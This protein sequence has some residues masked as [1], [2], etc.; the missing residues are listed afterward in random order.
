MP[1]VV[2]V[3]ESVGAGRIALQ[4]VEVKARLEGLLCETEVR[5]T[6][7]NLEDVNI[8]AVYTFPL[9][10]GAVLL[11][12]TAEING[13]S[14]ESTV[15]PKSAA[16]EGYEDAIEEG[17]S[18][19]LLE[20]PEPGLFTMNVG[21]LQPGETATI[22]L[23]YAELLHWQGDS[24]QFRLPTTIAPRYGDA[25]AAG[26]DA[27]QVP[28]HSLSAEHGFSLHIVI[29]GCLARA[30]FECPSHPLAVRDTEDA[31]ELH[32][33]GGAALM[34]RDF[35][36]IL[37]ETGDRPA[38]GIWARDGE[39]YVGLAS[40]HPPAV[41][42]PPAATC[43][44]IVV[45]CSGSM[46][47]DSIAQAKEALRRILALLEPATEFNLVL[48]GSGHRL[49][50][51][52][53]V[54]ATP[55]HLATALA[56]V[57]TIDADMGGT[58]IGAALDAAYRCGG[59]PRL[60]ASVLLVTD[61]EVWDDGAIVARAQ[62]SGHRIFTVG[63]GSA[64]SEAFVRALADATG[65]ACE[66]V[67]PREDMAEH[68]VRHFR[69]IGTPRAETLTLKWAAEPL[70]QAPETLD[71]V[72]AGDTVHVFVWT[73]EPAAGDATLEIVYPTGE[74]SVARVTFPRWTPAPAEMSDVLPRIAA[75]T[76]MRDLAPKD[77]AELAT[78]Y[79]LVTEHTSCLLV[80]HRDAHDR[81]TH[82]P[83]LR[84]VPNL[85]AAGWG[86]TGRCFARHAWLCIDLAAKLSLSVAETHYGP[87]LAPAA[88]R[89]RKALP[90]FVEA[91]NAL[92][93]ASAPAVLDIDTIDELEAL[94]LDE[95]VAGALRALVDDVHTEALVVRIFLYALTLDLGV[96]HT[97]SL[98][99]NLR[100]V[101]R[102]ATTKEMRESA[103]LPP[104]RDIVRRAQQ[105][106]NARPRKTG[107]T[108]RRKR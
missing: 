35:V 63:V 74:H 25:F 55:E 7:R 22:R 50:Y 43:L 61:G 11:E 18:A 65:G 15:L 81:A 97:Y 6:Y 106:S 2:A 36:L 44:K 37:R 9:P 80:R 108:R 56:F 59:S 17:D 107:P 24:L 78:Q 68:I 47:G 95:A 58:E 85:L 31:R 51:P 10:A 105:A 41:R 70:R 23:R 84:K 82:V 32:L 28:E 26:L 29:R 20:Q 46:A 16:T 48:F 39:T 89:G 92:Y 30:D 53:P 67:S 57:E 64:V 4:A 99:R 90:S 21:T 98:S 1:N 69:R 38:S 42:M 45:D 5:Q 93:P 101:L 33:S 86:G 102:R 76:R 104:I 79:R 8:E 27:H 94:G 54:P 66:L 19:I 52:E 60:P 62:K 73:S 91:L 49:L 88:T 103:L 12:V 3:L 13:V 40:F 87:S 100:R 14:L 72:Y 75:R 71:G 83:A 96:L 77:A 34:D